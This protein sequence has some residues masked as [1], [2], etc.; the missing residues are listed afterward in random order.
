[1]AW[2]AAEALANAAEDDDGSS[3]GGFESD[4]LTDDRGCTRAMTASC[5]HVVTGTHDA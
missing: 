5:G 1:M 4:G 3:V 2:A